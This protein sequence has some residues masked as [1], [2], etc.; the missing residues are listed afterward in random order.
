[1]LRRGA[2][3]CLLVCL[4]VCLLFFFDLRRAELRQAEPRRAR[5]R[6]PKHGHTGATRHAAD[7]SVTAHH[8]TRSSSH[9]ACHAPYPDPNRNPN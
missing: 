9:A 1:M 3:F 7:A 6:L 2:P 8:A 4:L 5:H